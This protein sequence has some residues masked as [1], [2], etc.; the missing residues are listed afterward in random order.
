[1]LFV[2]QTVEQEHGRFELI[3]GHVEGGGVR[4]QRD[5]ARRAAGPDLIF[6]PSCLG[7]GVKETPRDLDAAH[8]TL[9]HQRVERIVDLDMQAVGEFIGEPALR[10]LGNPRLK[11]GH[12]RPMARKPH[13]LL[14]P[15]A[16]LVKAS[17]RAQRVEPAPVAVAGEVAECLE[18]PED[19]EIGGRAQRV[20]QRREVGHLVAAQV[21]T[22]P[23]RIERRGT[24]NVRVPT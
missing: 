1:L 4:D 12:E 10:R 2:E 18:F 23:L 11:R 6:R 22:D 20:F 3:G 24:H 15:Q 9:A 21:R 5:G 17:D 14:G 8:A 19:G 7:G 16:V 13:R